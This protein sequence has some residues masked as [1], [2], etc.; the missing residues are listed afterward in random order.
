MTVVQNMVRFAFHCKGFDLV[1]NRGN[2]H[3]GSPANLAI[4]EAL[5]QAFAN[6]CTDSPKTV[7]ARA[8][9]F[10]GQP[11]ADPFWRPAR[12]GV[13]RN[14]ALLSLGLVGLGEA[15]RSVFWG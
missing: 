11:V 5:P 14:L 10:L 15:G 3:H 6:A 12:E 7:G 2:L 4:R 9:V 1:A 8:L 13:L